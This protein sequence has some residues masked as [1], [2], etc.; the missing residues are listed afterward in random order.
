MSNSKE[1]AQALRQFYR[2]MK[3][4]K[5][6]ISVFDF[7]FNTISC[8]CIFDTTISPFQLIF[9]KKI[10]AMQF[11]LPVFPGFNVDLKHSA[12][13][14]NNFCQFFELGLNGKSFKLFPFFNKLISSIPKTLNNLTDPQR[15]VIAKY[16]NVEDSDK[17]L[18]WGL[19]DWNTPKKD[20]SRKV[21]NRTEKNLV[22]TKLLYPEL[23]E[24]IK[25][26]NIS[27]KYTSEI[28]QSKTV[29]INLF[30]L[31]ELFHDV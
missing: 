30:Q 12:N 27:V 28:T 9:I 18:F 16:K 19:I 7:T 29:P 5:R 25:D 23:Y 21:G 20:G 17:L 2:E 8:S 6:H 26:E 31:D 10:T 1:L 13:S 24:L 3:V 14:F 11:C 4:T 22:K 15:S